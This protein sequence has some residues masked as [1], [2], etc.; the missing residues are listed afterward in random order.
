MAIAY[1]GSLPADESDAVSKATKEVNGTWKMV[2]RI[3]DGIKNSDEEVAGL[4]LILKDGTWKFSRNNEVTAEGK[5]KI[6]AIKDGVKTVDIA[7]EKGENA[8]KPLQH[9]SKLEG[10][11]LTTCQAP[12]GQACPTQFESKSGSGNVLTV[13]ERIEP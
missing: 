5:F 2:S 9:I 4:R 1:I 11:K 12:A 3:E 8:G 7:T 6:V 13:W 10:D